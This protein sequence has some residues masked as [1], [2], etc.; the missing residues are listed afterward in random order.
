MNNEPPVPQSA[1]SN[2]HSYDAL[3]LVSF[4]GPERPEDVLPFLE[5]VTRGKNVSRERLL[6]LA[7]RYWLFEGVSPINE[8]NRA[9]VRAVVAELNA[10]GPPLAVYWGNRHWHPLLPDTLQQMAGDGVRRA[11][12]FVTSAFGS[13]PGCRQYVEDIQRAC[14]ALGPQ[15]PQ[16]EKLRLFFNHPGFIEAMADR[17]LAALEEIPAERRA[18]ARLVYTA[19]SLPVDM[20]GCSPYQAQLAEACGLVSERIGRG[21]W[22]LVYQSRSV[23]G[24]GRPK[25]WLEPDVKDH[26]LRLHE[27]GSVKDVVLVPIGFLSEHIE[28]VYDLDVEAVGLGERLGINVVRAGVVGTHPRL[29]T[30]I[31]ELIEERMAECPARLALG[32]LGPWPDECPAECCLRPN[33]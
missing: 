11:L 6:Q 14:K 7:D 2:Q 15:A 17:V 31:R 22:D 32:A 4:G 13:Y 5:N 9:L 20:A 28:V 3:L 24:G 23:A 10:H 8:Q 12:A 27:A 21:E 19:H 33:A 18:A 30:M 16:V 29:V 26:L 25:P 1:I